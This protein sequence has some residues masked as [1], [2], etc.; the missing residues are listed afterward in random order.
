[1]GFVLSEMR[2][3]A[4]P[5][6]KAINKKTHS[7]KIPKKIYAKPMLVTFYD[8]DKNRYSQ[9]GNSDRIKQVR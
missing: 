5:Y 4:M 1:M 9:D 3:R 2:S 6:I 7:R 8:Q